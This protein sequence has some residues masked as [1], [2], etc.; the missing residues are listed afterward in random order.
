MQTHNKA[1][2]GRPS[3]LTESM[4]VNETDDHPEYL[5]RKWFRVR[6]KNQFAMKWVRPRLPDALDEQIISCIKNGSYP[7]LPVKDRPNRGMTFGLR[8]KNS[9]PLAELNKAFLTIRY[10]KLS[11]RVKILARSGRIRL[12]RVG[13][14]IMLYVPE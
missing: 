11:Y 2:T 4:T 13:R 7:G 3:K 14:G 5:V 12:W 9:M 6:G 8:V 1:K 10:H